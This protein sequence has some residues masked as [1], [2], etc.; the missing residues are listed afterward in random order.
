MKG[1]QSIVIH[2]AID[3]DACMEKRCRNLIYVM[4]GLISSMLLFPP[5][6][7][8]ARGTI[9]NMGYAFI[10][11][12]P[13]MGNINA[14]VRVEALIVEWLA[15][16]L[17]GYLLYRVFSGSEAVN[18][19]VQR[20]VKKDGLQGPSVVP[21]D[22][23]GAERT[24]IPQPKGNSGRPVVVLDAQHQKPPIPQQ[25]SDLQL[26]VAKRFSTF[27]TKFDL[28]LQGSESLKDLV[29]QIPRCIGAF[30]QTEYQ[31]LSNLH[32]KIKPAIYNPSSTYR[33]EQET[34][35]LVVTA[36]HLMSL[37]GNDVAAELMHHMEG[38]PDYPKSAPAHIVEFG[39]CAAL[40]K[41]YE[42]P[43]YGDRLIEK[44]N[45]EKSREVRVLVDAV[46]TTGR[47]MFQTH[48]LQ[49]LKKKQPVG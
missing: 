24:T 31:I 44:L 32:H 37:Y 12:P 20:L 46:V 8:H 9:Y 29:S 33:A 14:Q 28:R 41:Q 30:A 38:A 34:Y 21:L 22:K 45:L 4:V 49:N 11:T 13:K 5:F 40:Q 1:L 17:I 48:V 27:L 36:N 35:Y 26:E 39:G 18:T 25:N 10:F 43:G 15:V 42:V 23:Q 19:P 2:F 7:I 6:E 16:L 47:T 3:K